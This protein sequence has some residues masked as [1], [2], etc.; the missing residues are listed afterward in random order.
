MKLSSTDAWT[1]AVMLVFLVTSATG[2]AYVI[3][4]VSAFALVIG[5][6]MFSRNLLSKEAIILLGTV[7]VLVIFFALWKL[8][9]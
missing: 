7:S 3:F 6:L 5:I 2:N 8:T 1:I 4:V 9:R